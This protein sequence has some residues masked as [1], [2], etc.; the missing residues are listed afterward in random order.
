M[1][2]DAIRQKIEEQEAKNAR[3]L[4]ELAKKRNE[5]P[6]MLYVNFT[7]SFTDSVLCGRPLNLSLLRLRLQQLRFAPSR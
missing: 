5:Y 1:A 3:A 4:K 6:V 2:Q 7:F